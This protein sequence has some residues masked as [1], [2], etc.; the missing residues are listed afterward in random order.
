MK[1]IIALTFMLI[2]LLQLQ[3][4]YFAPI[5]A[6]W[7]YKELYYGSGETGILTAEVVKDTIINDKICS[8]IINGV[9]C[10]A[11]DAQVNYVF[12]EDSIVYFFNSTTEAFEILHNFKAKTG[13]SWIIEFFAMEQAATVKATVQT[14]STVNI[15]GRPLIHQTIKYTKPNADPLDSWEY[16]ADVLEII[17]DIT[18]LFNLYSPDITC[19]GNSSDGL[20]S[21]NDSE[22]GTYS[23]SNGLPFEI[24]STNNWKIETFPNPTDG[25]FTIAQNENTISII[26]L[27]D[28][29]GKFLCAKSYSKESM[30]D[31]NELPRGFYIGVFKKGDKIVGF[32]KIIKQ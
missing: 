29:T 24:N 7:Q 8:K 12:Q 17:G 10:G 13:D 4:Q 3:G 26:E 22:L 16:S 25:Q 11:Y 32:N 5:G 9:L 19:D 1:K 31:I 23:P 20:I 27:Y 15:N 21:Y 30:V 6:V 14:V 28:I 18:F 2:S